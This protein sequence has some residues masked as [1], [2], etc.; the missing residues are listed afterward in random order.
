M[1]AACLFGLHTWSGCKCNRCSKVRD[2][3]HEWDSCVC[4]KCGKTRTGLDER[5]GRTILSH[6]WSG[7]PLKCIECDIKAPQ[8][9]VRV[10]EGIEALAISALPTGISL[11]TFAQAVRV[12]A[13]NIETDCP[14]GIAGFRAGESIRLGSS[15]SY[16]SSMGTYEVKFTLHPGYSEYSLAIRNTD[17]TH[18]ALRSTTTIKAT[19]M[20]DVV[21]IFE[22]ALHPCPL[23]DLSRRDDG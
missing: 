6:R 15:G 13:L 10:A 9:L 18:I 1:N 16:T 14:G 21:A 4:R 7:T 5:G 11:H 17:P 12:A 2:S 3:E 8:D 23:C 19:T 22:M 20:E